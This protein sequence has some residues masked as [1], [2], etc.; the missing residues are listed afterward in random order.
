MVH[1]HH[2]LV[3]LCSAMKKGFLQRGRFLPA[4]VDAELFESFRHQCH[5]LKEILG[6]SFPAE[7]SS[8]GPE[9]WKVSNLHNIGETGQPGWLSGLAQPSAQ[10]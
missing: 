9:L 3:V 2:A 4:R 10:E 1:L 8:F 5:S 6:V 7:V